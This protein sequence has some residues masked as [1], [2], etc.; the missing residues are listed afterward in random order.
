M[1]ILGISAYYHDS[2]AAL[3]SEDGVLAAA[4]EE[5]FTRIKNDPAFPINA[6][7]YCLNSQ[8]LTLADI[9][10]I[11]YYE[12]PLLKFERLLKTFYK[13]SPF[14]LVQFIK[15]MP[16]WVKKKLFL[17]SDIKKQ[18]KSHLDTDTVPP[19]LFP[20]HHLSHAASAYFTSGYNESV[21]VTLDGVG[22]WSTAGIYKAEASDITL[23][24]SLDF[25]DSLGLLYSSFTYFLGFEVNKGEYKLMGLAPYGND[26]SDDYLRF[27][28]IIEDNLVE[29]FEDGSIHL[30]S[31]YFLYESGS[32][33]I[34]VSKWENLFG[35]R[36]RKPEDKLEQIH[37]DLGL[38]IQHVTEKIVLKIVKYAQSLTESKNLCLA[39]G[40]A[41][42][43]VANGKIK[44]AGLFSNIYVQPAAGDA[45]GA[46][47]AA[48]ITMSLFSEDCN[49]KCY[50]NY[51]LLGPEFEDFE[52]E[53]EL[54]KR[55]L[56]FRKV[57]DSELVDFISQ[58]LLDNKYV[59]W[60]QGRMEFG[61]RA[62]GNRSILG[63]A[64]SD[65][66]QKDL[67]LKIKF[68]ES[69]RPFAPIMLQEE[70]HQYFDVQD[71]EPF[72][73]FVH[74]LKDSFR[75]EQP[76]YNRMDMTEKLYVPKSPFPAVT[77]VDYSSRVQT[78]NSEQNPMIFALL[79]KVKEIS[80]I[81][82]LVNTSF[83]VKDEP[84]VC[85]PSNAIDCYLNTGLDLLVLGNYLL[86]KED[87]SN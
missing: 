82:M 85:T 72:M 80:G 53:A 47:G 68:R 61:P 87:G 56:S 3:I 50:T 17:K 62:L 18:L 30:K 14:G 55:K 26:A 20:E 13:T 86:N 15:S 38:A 41:L 23:L 79:K 70:A 52:I 64:F 5:R 51:S 84:I 10:Y 69:F 27:K 40:V 73:L 32:K 16:I 43:C 2:A 1:L 42:N 7:K 59:G 48:L 81:G 9:D 46:L 83:N 28:Q 49:A 24:K 78:V 77:H 36:K 22:E 45:G 58:K 44:K 67:N 25:P 21:I 75:N 33:M 65:S 19:F 6:I 31:S 11:S 60:F 39:G 35:L 29:V 66:T 57:S 63:N 76:N 37:C 4:Q 71:E 8:G 34:H 54:N 12:K 74:K